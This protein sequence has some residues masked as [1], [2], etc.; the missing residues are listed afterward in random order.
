MQKFIILVCI[1]IICGCSSNKK[2]SE[3]V[4]KYSGESQYGILKTNVADLVCDC[5][6]EFQKRLESISDGEVLELLNQGE[7]AAQ[8]V[9]ADQLKRVQKAI[10]L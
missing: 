3:V 6:G 2:L 8:E 4:S 5:L 10:G 7:K 1:T 9:S